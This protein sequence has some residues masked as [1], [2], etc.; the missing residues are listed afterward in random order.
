[1]NSSPARE[2]GGARAA[3]SL[4]D[5]SPSFWGLAVA[6]GVAAG[7]GAIA[8]M[9]LLH[10]VQHAAFS[11]RTGEYS[12]AVARHGDLR[13]LLVVFCGGVVAG[14]GWWFMRR[15][16]GGTGGEP[17]RAVWSG[18]DDLSLSRT[19]LS[20]ALSEVVI[21]LGA[22]LG[23]EAAPQQA[24][25]AFGAWIGRRFA[26]PRE[27]RMLL[28]ACGAGAGVGAVYNVPF[29]GA[30]FAAE[31][32][33][34]SIGL[35]AIVPALVTST[36]ATAVGWIS[37]PTRA[38]Y[39]L[40]ALPSPSAGFLCWAL[41]AGPVFGVAAAGLVRLLAWAS[42]RRRPGRGLLIEPP[43]AFALLGLASIGYPL[44]LGNGRD[45]AQF[46]F[47]GAGA[48][49]TLA[50]LAVLKP[51]V[52]A[53]C[54]RSGA[55]GGLFTPTLSTGA[56]LGALL[57]RVWGLV[58][59]GVPAA[60]CALAGGG[61]MLA[62]GMQ[63]PLAAIAFTIELTNTVNSS[64]VAVLVAVAGGVIVAR[65]LEPRSIYTARATAVAPAREAERAPGERVP[66]RGTAEGEAKTTRAR[67][68][69][70]RPS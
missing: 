23:R 13:R 9:A 42:E 25:A 2:R 20:G 26:L 5:L 19:V 10:A 35:A 49:A 45:L 70:G 44:L 34:G 36:T 37:L 4:A 41:L 16:L 67:T 55:R 50:A 68:Q 14:A 31:V 47:T 3:G 24:G 17:T 12:T 53:M 64:L 7:V 40:P 60:G 61:A 32:Y 56:V 21:G 8:M 48:L 43:V 39:R 66:R 33:L 29:A 30:L 57:G 6:T 65:R 58:L 51:V 63:A 18:R 22:S 15:R 38:V 69:S 27:Q 62:A 1:V 54:I 46:A 11:Y 52:T 28:I 59:P